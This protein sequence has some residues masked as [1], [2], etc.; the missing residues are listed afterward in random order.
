MREITVY[1]D[2]INSVIRRY[3]HEI[4]RPFKGSYMGHFHALNL[5]GVLHSLGE[6]ERSVGN[7]SPVGLK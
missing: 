3:K 7:W 6:A 1:E 4:L 2:A 5:S